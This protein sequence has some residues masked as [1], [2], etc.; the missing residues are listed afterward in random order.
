MAIG[1]IALIYDDS[2]RPDTTGGYCLRALGKKSEVIHFRPEQLGG[3]TP[4]FDLY[5]C[6]DDGLDYRLPSELRPAAYWAIDTHLNFERTLRRVGDFDFIFAAQKEGAA[7]LRAEGAARCEWLPLACDPEIHRRLKVARDYDVAFIGNSFHGPRQQILEQ[8]KQR[9]PNSFIGNAPH[10]QMGEIYSRAKIVIN[11]CLNN[12]LNMR[13][14]EALACGALLITNH[15]KNNGQEE[16]FQDRIHLVE[17]DTPEKALE[18]I[19]SYLRHPEERER[20]AEAGYQEVIAK[21]T[22]RQRMEQ[23]LEK[24]E[25]YLGEAP[26]EGQATAPKISGAPTLPK[27]DQRYFHWTRPDLLELVPREAK[28]VLDV[29]CAAGVLGEAL[30]QSQECEVIGIELDRGAAEEAKERLDEVIQGDVETLDFGELGKFDAIV[31]GDI[32]EHLRE[33]GEV[34]KKLRDLLNPEG[35]LIASF[36]NVR[37]MEVVQKLVEGNWTYEP[38]G[39]LDRDHLRF[40]TRRSAEQL[41]EAAGFETTQAR[42]VP[43]QGYGEWEKAGRP[44]ELRAGRLGISGLSREEAEEFFVGQWLIRAKPAAR[45]DWGLTS[46]IILTWNQLPYT[47]MCLESIRKH[48]HQPYELIMVDNGSTDGT[49]DWLRGQSDI[50]LIANAENLGF[51]KGVNQGLAAAGGENILLLN[52]DTVVTPGWLQRLLEGLYSEAEVGMVGPVSNVVSGPQQIS[53]PYQSLAGLEGFAWD[54]GRAQRGRRDEYDRLVGF[55]LLIKRGVLKKIGELDERFGLGNFEDDDLCMRARQAGYKLLIC[56]DSFIHHFGGRSFI[57]NQLPS[58]DIMRE[59]YLRYAEKW[60]LPKTLPKQLQPEKEK[61]STAPP[62]KTSFGKHASGGLLLKKGGPKISL[63]MIVRNEDPHIADCL[64]SIAPYVDEM[65][66]VDTGS[67]DRTPE[68]ARS[69]GAKVIEIEWPDSF[70]AARNVSLDHA[71]GDWIFWM[72]ADDV[73]DEESGRALRT[74]AEQ[75]GENIL[76]FIAQV[77]CPA[78]PGEDGETVVDH[79]KLFRNRPDLRFELRMH[80]QILP[81]LRRA[82]GEIARAPIH[83]THAHYDHSPQ[84]QKKKRERDAYLLALDLQENPDHPFVHFNIGMTA[85]HEK[86]F[87]KAIKHLRAS[88]DLSAPQDSQVRKAYALLASSY[89]AMGNGPEA[90]KVCQEGQNYYPEDAELLFNEALAWQLSGNLA[91]AEHT[92]LQLLGQNKNSDY[93]ASVD[94]GI[95]S[96]KARH[97]LGAIYEQMGATDKAEQCFREVIAEEQGFLP[98]WLALGELLINNGKK[99]ALE[100]LAGEAATVDEVIAALLRGRWALRNN[101]LP[102]AE[103]HFREIMEKAPYREEGYRFLSHVLLQRGERREV[104]GVL[105]RLIDL[106]PEDAEAH[107]NLGSLLL[108][109]ARAAEAMVYFQQALNLRPG[110]ERSRQMLQVCLEKRGQEGEGS[111]SLSEPVLV[112]GRI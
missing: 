9:Y 11:C 47:Q 3:I 53:V 4:E 50:Q 35:P 31:C 39:L 94:T 96:Y 87:P 91:E 99:D 44:G 81:S 26:A 55:C 75:A 89:R 78:G 45:V 80:E 56:R 10:T 112:G 82:G 54:W 32:L 25:G 8:V 20:I 65:I 2:L 72:D 95:F 29:G 12:D 49:A 28:R 46:I 68:I 57:G 109:Q 7:R 18:L 13:V 67:T 22:Y 43:S 15:L 74:S 34:L 69:L 64:K 98:S 88:I 92:F 83:V 66:V 108:E 30:K 70:S 71:A 101:E 27:H 19:D 23:L 84:G 40:Y 90:L 86:D 77:H 111:G 52:N 59:N 41:L 1:K 38:A 85:F 100:K 97:N 5:L 48:T 6:I 93:L 16:L 110:Y 62:K 106:A 14:F 33:P 17:Y 21:H 60:N 42:A 105:C 58:G 61:P 76:G 107:H 51:A 102:E 36:P 79:V 103:K 37:H 63:C 104:E 73:I 24:V